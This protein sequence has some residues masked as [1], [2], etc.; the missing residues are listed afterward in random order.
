MSFITLPVLLFTVILS[1]IATH[2]YNAK[3]EKVLKAELDRERI[4]LGYADPEADEEELEPLN[5]DS[6]LVEIV[7]ECHLLGQLSC[8]SGAEGDDEDVG[9]QETN[10]PIL[11]NM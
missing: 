1:G 6:E 11:S 8:D 4:R 7:R 9:S 5:L 3:Q 2:I 10:S